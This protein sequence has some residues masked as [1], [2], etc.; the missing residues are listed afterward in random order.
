MMTTAI[1]ATTQFIIVFFLICTAFAPSTNSLMGIVVDADENERSK[2]EILQMEA[3][4][5]VTSAQSFQQINLMK[6]T[7]WQEWSKWSKC[8]K[9]ERFRMRF[10]SCVLDDTIGSDIDAARGALCEVGKTE[11]ER[12]HC[13]TARRTGSKDEKLSNWNPFMIEEE[14]TASH[15]KRPKANP[16]PVRVIELHPV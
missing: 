13:F 2:A 7:S 14:I 11:T 3:N 12:Q 9:E 5:P 1:L 8:G 4:S 6:L 16:E 10:R 15:F